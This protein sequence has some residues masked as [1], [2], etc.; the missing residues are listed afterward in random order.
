M[1]FWQCPEAEVENDTLPFGRCSG[2][3]RGFCVQHQP[4]LDFAAPDFCNDARSAEDRAFAQECTQLRVGLQ[5]QLLEPA[6][7]H[8]ALHFDITIVVCFHGSVSLE[9]PGIHSQLICTRSEFVCP[10]KDAAVFLMP[11]QTCQNTVSSEPPGDRPVWVPS[12]FPPP[13]Q[14]VGTNFR[15]PPNICASSFRTECSATSAMLRSGAS[16][17]MAFKQQLWR[18][19]T[20]LKHVNSIWRTCRPTVTRPGHC[21]STE[22]CGR[23]IPPTAALSSS[24]LTLGGA[25]R[26]GVVICGP[27]SLRKIHPRGNHG[28]LARPRKTSK[29]YAQEHSA[30]ARVRTHASPSE[31]RVAKALPAF[32]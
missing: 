16:I 20:R 11:P 15:Y 12:C 14:Q 3:A 30:S 10:R 26:N 32:S 17:P 18:P 31:S 25:G 24:A 28:T 9:F 29:I 27:P 19:G 21:Y 5:L 4:F 1:C 8:K 7:F 22:T 2:H 13:F 23:R 6:M